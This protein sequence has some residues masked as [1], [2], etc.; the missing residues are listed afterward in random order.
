VEIVDSLDGNTVVEN[1]R[2]RQKGTT[3]SKGSLAET[4]V[5]GKKQH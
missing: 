1:A 3:I 4:A 2:R 5:P